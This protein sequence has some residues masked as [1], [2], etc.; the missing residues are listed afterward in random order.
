M[1][2][3]LSCKKKKMMNPFIYSTVVKGENFYDREEECKHIVDTL[4]G[5]NSIIM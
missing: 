5:F 2:N 4:V 3:I 1:G